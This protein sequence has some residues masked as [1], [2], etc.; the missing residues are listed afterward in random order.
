[1]ITRTIYLENP[2]KWFDTKE[3]KELVEFCI[4]YI[5]KKKTVHFDFSPEMVDINNRIH[6]NNKTKDTDAYFIILSK[7]VLEVYDGRI[8]KSNQ[9]SK[10]LH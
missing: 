2:E 1:M 8:K 3:E 6:V 5:Q 7:R 9:R 10:R 4:N